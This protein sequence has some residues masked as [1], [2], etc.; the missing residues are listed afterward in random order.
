M[1]R[2]QQIFRV[3]ILR[4]TKVEYGDTLDVLILVDEPG[5][6]IECN[7]IDV[8][9]TNISELDDYLQKEIVNF[10]NTYT[11]LEKKRIQNHRKKAVKTAMGL[12]IKQTENGNN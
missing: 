2:K 6:I 8:L 4:N 11:H 5:C 12:I 7:T 10:F 3:Q 9:E 1:F